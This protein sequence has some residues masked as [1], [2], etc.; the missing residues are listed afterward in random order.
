MPYRELGTPEALKAALQGI[1]HVI[2]DA[3]ERA[4]RR[5]QGAQ[6]QVRGLVQA[7]Q[8]IKASV[9][10]SEPKVQE[11]VETVLTPPHP[12]PFEAL[13]NEPFTRTLDH[14]TTQRYA[15]GLLRL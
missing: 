15:Q 8:S 6:L 14:A 4:Y 1:D 2:I 13:L 5:S 9:D 12:D 3:T 7:E 10:P 11:M